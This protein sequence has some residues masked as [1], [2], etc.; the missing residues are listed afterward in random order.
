LNVEVRFLNHHVR[1]HQVEQL[2]L[3][4]DAVPALDERLQE[5]EHACAR[6]HGRAVHQQQALAGTPL[7]IGET[8]DWLRGHRTAMD[9]RR[10][11]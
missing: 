6:F 5:V 2:V 7:G 9:G 8:Y 1:P 10:L 11:V 3:A 4:D